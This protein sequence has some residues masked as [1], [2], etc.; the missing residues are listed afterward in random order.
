MIVLPHESK[1]SNNISNRLF[2]AIL[3]VYD[4]INYTMNK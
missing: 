3:N 1:K 2:E 4:A